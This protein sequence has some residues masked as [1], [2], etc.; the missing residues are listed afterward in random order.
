M[1]AATAG[2]DKMALISVS[3]SGTGRGMPGEATVVCE[4]DKK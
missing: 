2:T 3:Y 4:R 1:T